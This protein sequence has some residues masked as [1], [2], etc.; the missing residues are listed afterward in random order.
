M[1]HIDTGSDRLYGGSTQCC[2]STN[3]FD[4]FKGNKRFWEATDL[5]VSKIYKNAV[6]VGVKGGGGA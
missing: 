4:V 2:E 6:K 3:D 5:E 1:K